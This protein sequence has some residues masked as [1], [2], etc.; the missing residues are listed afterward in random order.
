MQQSGEMSSYCV[1]V[2]FVPASTSPFMVTLGTLLTVF[3]ACSLFARH[4]FPVR[5]ISPDADANANDVA[6]RELKLR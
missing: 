3:I 2:V 5:S 4:T 1:H 6:V